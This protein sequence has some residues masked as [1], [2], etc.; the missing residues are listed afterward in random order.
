MKIISGFA[1]LALLSCFVTSVHAR[2]Y[3]G[4]GIPDLTKGGKL[5]RINKRWVGPVG[6]HCGS[7]RARQ[8]S[9]DQMYIRQLQ[10]LE[11]DKGSPADGNLEV[12]DVI[13]G[14]DGTGAAKVP[15]FKGA[16]WAMIPIAD[17]IT[18]AEAR[19]PAL[20]KLLVWRKGET[21]TVTIELETLGRYSE[22]APYNCEKSKRILRKG[23]KAFYE[24]DK[25]DKAG[26]GVLCLLAADDPT[27]PDNDKYQAR[28][29]AWAHQ[30]EHGGSP[31]FS[32]PKL[33]ALSEYYMKTKDESIFPKL[34]QQAEYHANGVSWFGTAGHRWCEKQPDGSGNGRIAGY[35]PI[36]C[37]GALGYLGL[38]LARKA[39][40]K[41]PVV[42]ASHKAQRIFFG[43][44]AFRGGMG[45]GEHPYGIGGAGNDYNGK[46]AMSG[47]AIGMDEGR[48]EK[49]KYF[50][51]M[52]TLATYSRR[53]YAHGG[54]YFGQVWHPIGA[55]QG[56]MKAANLQFREIRWH[57][58]LKRRW[59]NTR[60]HDSSNCERYKDFG[61]AATALIFYAAPLKQLYI[62]GRGRKES[63]EFTDA[64]FAEVL[65]T[66][67]FDASKATTKELVAA[68]SRCQ[69]LLR[70]AAAD[71]L[72]RR[73]KEKPDSPEWPALIDQLLALATDGEAGPTGRAGAC[74]VLLKI[75]D[76]S[77]DAVTAMKN[78]EIAKTM[79]TLLKDPD[80][81]VRFAGVRVLQK[82]DPEA[83]RPHVDEILD[84]VVAT[85]R[86]TFPLDEE[87]PLQW[88]HGAMGELLFKRVLDKSIDG[89]DRAKLIPAIRSLL[90]TPNGGSRGA[91]T[92]VLSKL[93]KEETLAIADVLVDN[94]RVPPPGNAMG[95]GGAVS[96]SQST[97]AKHLFEEAL[98]LSAYYGPQAAL[99]NKIPQKYGKAALNIQAAEVFLQA[100]GD[101]I[102]IQAID[103]QGVVDGI[104]KG[105]MPDKLYKLKRI[106][107]IKAANATLKL[108]AVKT[109]L[110]VDATNF[111][112]RGENETAYTWR[113]VYGA[114]EVSFTP[115]ASGQSKKTTVT[116]TDKKP[117]TYRFE[118]AMSDTLGLNVVRKT[119]DV[120]LY[121]ERGKLPANKPPQAKSQSLQA[122]P[123]LPVPV[124]LS[125]TDPDGDDLGFVV[126]QQPAHGKL[127][128]V[129]GKLTYTAN[130]GHNGT[131]RFTFNAIDGQGKT[132]AGTIDLKV[133]DK[134]V[135][136]AVYEGFDYP[137][138]GVH[139]C[140]GGAS[141]GF[142]GPWQN[143]RKTKENYLVDTGTP[144]HPEKG[145]SLSYPSLPS[146]GGRLTGG[147]HTS[148]SRALEPKIL[149]AH[150]LLGHGQELWL[151]I[152]VEGP[153]LKME[154]R[155]PELGLGFWI[156]G[157]K[158]TI[159]ATLNGEK[160]G[161]SR[162]PWSRSAKLRFSEKTPDMIIMRC[163][164]G[165]TEKDPDTLEIYRVFDAPGFGPLV[166]KKPACVLQEII[167]QEKINTV[168]MGFS[169]NRAVDE[170]RIGPTLHSVMVGTKPLAAESER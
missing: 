72:A 115:N 151:S 119:V 118:V 5:T 61:Y 86:P 56:G 7:W 102:L 147:K 127:S 52:A 24:S 121:D 66:K 64:E 132:A 124:T 134:N 59:D 109:E 39:G 93:T 34:V 114:G 133:S 25:P 76:R 55:T 48:E 160:A 164:W 91:T 63:L 105:A 44:Y 10:V 1:I 169:Q 135:G 100:V 31:W 97:L 116:F 30:I 53:Q 159:D 42:E 111:G 69:G 156:N 87:D 88:A 80:A 95:G 139:G 20:L 148:C 138:G 85:G 123:G 54:S 79:A 33:M 26:F 74:C 62:T 103:A 45:Y 60:I 78:A 14:A 143:S 141:F 70:S 136:V 89:V 75:K 67:Q 19:N 9:D 142:S 125:G 51:R 92:H 94:I 96:N 113:K 17:A 112:R 13:L 110:I 99:K 32:G 3:L 158:Y 11:V 23:V 21:K 77:N 168:S 2:D 36:T 12:G 84:A 18:E 98:P 128:G 35:G 90:K 22:T 145:S 43:H 65:E 57:L 107:A 38:S 137:A 104:E 140:E 129:G 150:N 8:R 120:T 165:K 161:T 58:D 154:L 82:L 16:D 49:A 162:N 50:T 37:S 28:A 6:I 73:V 131:D 106:D 117:G 27:N 29:K 81:Y 149:A 152:F 46:Q 163:V 153:D 71:E 68:L 4:E 166:L 170:I 157:H 41:S 167:P 130:F 144:K 15:L 83:V 40:V 126:T 108:P 146:T 47:L 155:G 101:Q 122:A